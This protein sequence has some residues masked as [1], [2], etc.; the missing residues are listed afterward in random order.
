MKHVEEIGR[1]FFNIFK[2]KRASI[3]KDFL[4]FIIKSLKVS[5]IK[6]YKLKKKQNHFIFD[7]SFYFN[8]RILKKK[9]KKEMEKILLILFSAL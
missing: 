3:Q 7:Y 6:K 1:S 2:K 4:A 9:K 8:K 5:I